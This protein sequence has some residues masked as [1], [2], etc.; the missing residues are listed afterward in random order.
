M[1][2]RMLAK[3]TLI[4][5]LSFT[6]CSTLPERKAVQPT[7]SFQID[8]TDTYLSKLF[9]KQKQ[10]T[11]ELTGYHILFNP[12]DA[13]ISRL[14][15]IE[16]AEKSLDLQYYIWDNDKMGALALAALLKAADRGVHV[17][18]LI[19]DNNSKHLEAAYYA[20]DQHPNIEI[21]YFNPFKYR[22][23]RALDFVLDF[24]RLT[25]RMH[26]K[27]FI[28]DHEVALIGGRN[29]SNQYFNASDNFQFSDM[30]VILVGNAVNDITNSFDEYW[31]HEYAYPVAQLSQHTAKRL[32]YESLKKQLEQHWF[33]SHLEDMNG[34]LSA[35][36]TFD[37]WFNEDLKFNWVD[38][39]IIADPAD[40]I[41]KETD[42]ESS[43]AFQLQNLVK[44]PKDNMDLVS[45]YFVPEKQGV[46]LL[47]ESSEK[48]VK[49][50]VL[51]NSFKANDVPLVHAF[52]AQ[53]REDLLKSGIEV[54]EFL[55]VLP[56]I[57][58]KKERNKVIG[59]QSKFNRAGLSKS[60]LH[61]KFMA[62][63][64]QQVFIGSFNLDPRS[65]YLN[66]EIGVILESPELAS[67]IHNEM[68][69][70]IMK[71]AYR[72][73]LDENNKLRWIHEDNGKQYIYHSEPRTAWWQRLGLKMLTWLP[74]EKQM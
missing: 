40:K 63:D 51:T 37:E 31:N 13:L 29:M 56:I 12:E 33:V 17:R 67:T 32:S 57:L 73:E 69:Q 30:D 16:R 44:T 35:A 28:A 68:N 65:A 1:P 9:A 55:P 19:D 6:A 10:L 4:S 62:F 25:R 52:Y 36:L 43:F 54:Y 72:V 48:G 49:I 71:Y 2:L 11:P 45:A 58:D 22:R 21:R 38:A 18:L 70:N 60:S 39:V 61:A 24:N 15:L 74:I 50:R 5:S 14:Q 7:Y 47:R 46:D 59:D 3:L 42:V 23:V 26:N 34:V 64:Q 41:K 20:L 27:T 66:T 53:Y 8:T